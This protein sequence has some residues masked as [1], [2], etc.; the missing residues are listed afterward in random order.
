MDRPIVVLGV[1]LVAQDRPRLRYEPVLTVFVLT[2]SD[3]AKER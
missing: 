1:A 2:S 3:F